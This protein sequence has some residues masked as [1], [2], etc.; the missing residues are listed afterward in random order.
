MPGLG[1]LNLEQA[2]DPHFPRTGVAGCHPETPSPAAVAGP[3]VS[4]GSWR[5]AGRETCSGKVGLR[6]GK[7]GVVGGL[8]G[9]TER[10][11]GNDGF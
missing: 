1:Q 5:E 8:V 3:G 11:L 2:A 6:L 4:R 10:K 7:E 9:E